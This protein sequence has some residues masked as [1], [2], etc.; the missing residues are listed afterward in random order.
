MPVSVFLFFSCGFRDFS[1]LVDPVPFLFLFLFIYY[2]SS[3]I[4]SF[5]EGIGVGCLFSLDLS[6]VY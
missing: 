6:N 2:D 5:Y 3:E 4:D 1:F